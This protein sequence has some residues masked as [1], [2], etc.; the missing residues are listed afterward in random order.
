M[1]SIHC[2]CCWNMGLSENGVYHIPPNEHLNLNMENICSKYMNI[3]KTHDNRWD[4]FGC[5]IF[6]QFPYTRAVEEP[7]PITDHHCRLV[8]QPGN[9]RATACSFQWF[10]MGIVH[11]VS[12]YGFSPKLPFTSE[13]WL[14]FARGFGANSAIFSP[15]MSWSLANDGWHLANLYQRGDPIGLWHQ[16]SISW[17]FSTKWGYP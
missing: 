17:G 10:S 4:C 8:L 16:R 3:W 1:Q 5:T 9:G 7:D 15:A 2:E 6:R 14:S 12:D 11:S 13:N